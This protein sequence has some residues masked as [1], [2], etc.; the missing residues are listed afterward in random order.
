MGN[1]K[2]PVG[3]PI[4]DPVLSRVLDELGRAT[5]L[6]TTYGP[7]HPASAA[8]Q[9]DVIQT[10]HTLLSKRKKVLLGTFN[11]VLTI[12]DVPIKTMGAL[13]KSLER[14][15]NRL[16][17]TG[18]SIARGISKQEL[19]QLTQLL[20]CT[21]AEAFQT[22]LE[23]SPMEHVKTENT[24]FQA[25]QEGQIVVNESDLA[26]MAGINDNGVLVLDDETSEEQPAEEAGT[27]HVDQIVAFLKGDMD[28]TEGTVGEELTELAS[29]P[30]RLAKL[31]ME[32]VAIRQS[33]SE[34]SGESISDIILGCLRRTYNGLRKQPAFQATEGKADLLKSLL[35]LEE[36]V[37]E[38]MRELVGEENPEL[39]RLIVQTIR[40]MKEDVHFE[41]AAAQYMTHREAMEH[42]RQHLQQFIHT[43]GAEI[44][45]TLLE[46]SGFPGADWRKIVID[47]GK[48]GKSDAGSGLSAGLS[49]LASV[50]EKLEQLMKSKT[51]D[52]ALVKDLLGEVNHNLDDTLDT[53]KDKLAVL[54]QQI[55]ENGAATIGGQAREMSRE[56]LL[57]ALS[58]VAQELMQPLTAINA[59][60]EMMLS[61]YVGNVTDEQHDLLTLASNSGEHLKFLMNLLIDIVGCP[62]NKGIDPRFHTTSDEVVLM[63]DAERSD[64]SSS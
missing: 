20:S 53:T 62:I 43:K 12:D 49:K 27:V 5:N 64:P 14:R 11:N 28:V 31:I 26:G 2:Q 56:E 19:V 10:T 18:L 3:Q 32:S 41:I 7:D 24:R 42:D 29:D 58:E 22:G 6:I 25:M 48:G 16:R 13:Q 21:E 37:L 40:G 46:G 57:A 39:D 50:F 63:K 44:A 59:S 60:L 4:E 51:A 35:L 34:L 54:S 61:G 8:V 30:S 47:S 45:E 15:L 9:E 33:V 52:G 1:K 17:I 38:S 23:N 36:S 55:M